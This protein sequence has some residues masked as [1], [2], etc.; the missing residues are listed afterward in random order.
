MAAIVA[1][2]WLGEAIKANK[3]GPSLRILDAS[4][5]LPKLNRNVINEF[6]E[7]HISGASFFDIDQCCDKTSSLDHMLPNEREFAD[8]VGNLGI[9]NQT[10]V[11]VYDTSD[12]GSFSA[13]RVWWMF[14]VFGH[15]LVSVLDGGLKKWV[16]EGHP[17]TAEY[18]TPEPTEFQ[19]SL[20]RSWVKS[21]EDVLENIGSKQFQLVDARSSGRFRGI[22]PE[23][24]DNVEPGHIPGSVNMPF[25]S[26][27]APSGAELPTRDLAAMFEAAG[28]DLKRPLCA[29]CGSGV[30]ACHV[31]L[32]AHLCGYPGV[33]VYDGSWSDWYGRAPPSHMISEAKGEEA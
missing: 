24:R 8:Y 14:R 17:V 16:Q 25:Y 7:R 27:L 21:Y 23:P 13:P 18:S 6:N 19:A 29:T 15:N 5:Y 11:V 33:T 32:A 1:A 10:H 12:F 9:G 4:W 3:I 22:E 2:K 28:V 31:A 26:F 20:N 30:T